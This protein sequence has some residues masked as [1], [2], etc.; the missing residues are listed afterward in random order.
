MIKRIRRHI[1]CPLIAA[2]VFGQVLS[3]PAGASPGCGSEQYIVKYREGCVP[4]DADDALPFDVVKPEKFEQLYSDGVLEWYEPDGEVLLLGDGNESYYDIGQWNLEQI[5]ADAAFSKGYLGTG[6]RVGVID[7]GVN[8]HS[9][10][11]ERL[12]EGHNYIEGAPDE[13]DTSDNFGHGTRVAGLIAGAGEN[14]CSGVAPEAVI[15][16]LKITDGQAVKVSAVCRAI[17]GAIDDYGCDIL[18]LSLGVTAEY[19]ALKEAVDYAEEKNVLIVSAVGNSGS[20]A[21]YYPAFYDTVVG[22]GAVDSEGLIY[23]NSNHNGSVF[24]TAPGVDV[25]SIAYHGGYTTSSG[26]SFSV[27]QVTG[28]AAVLLGINSDL[29]P[30]ELRTLLSDTASDRGSE[31][32][33]EYYGYGIINLADAVKEL[34]DGSF[35]TGGYDCSFLPETGAAEAVR[36]NTDRTV[37]CTYIMAEYDGSGR[38]TGTAAFQMTIEPG[39]TVPVD[40]P[41]GVEYYGQFLCDTAS[42]IP[43]TEARVC[44]FS[45]NIHQ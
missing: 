37:S 43:L 5:G 9:D 38:C 41:A 25:R 2:L 34:T 27:P 17:Y 3:P 40:P 30:A 14:G 44:R 24:V 4:Q 33:D 35:R 45:N 12:L 23:R 26:T 39:K 11:G 16:P 42:M 20:S 31:G 32:Y 15:V 13:N 21:L 1:L 10:L 36:N 19:E 8:R 6:V 18:N 7:S 22:V 29:T 28:A